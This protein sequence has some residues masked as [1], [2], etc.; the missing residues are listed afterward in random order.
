MTKLSDI[1]KKII[2]LFKNYPIQGEKVKNF[3]DFCKVDELIKQ[4]KHLMG[5]GLEQIRIIKAGMNRGR[6]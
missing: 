5:D 1:I 2:P 3:E 6:N 4:K